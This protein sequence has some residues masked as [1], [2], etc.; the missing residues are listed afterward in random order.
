M[1]SK[2]AGVPVKYIG[3]ED[4]FYDR[5]YGSNLSFEREQ[6]RV[7]SD[8]DLVAKFLRHSDCFERVVIAPAAPAPAP[9]PAPVEP[10]THDS[11][12]TSGDGGGGEGSDGGTAESAAS[13]GAGGQADGAPSGDTP[14]ADD[15]T[16]EQEDDTDAVLAEAKKVEE[17]RRLAEQNRLD[18]V[19]TLDSMDKD[20]L[21]DWGFDKFQQKVPKTLSVENMRA[22]LVEMID[23]FGVP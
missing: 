21:Q 4:P 14:P 9:A 7:I 11:E 8:L 16:Q 1:A 20:Q 23:Q 6:V 3:R 5:L 13:D 22:R 17:A 19:Q 10:D 15:G 18:L 12:S 2:T